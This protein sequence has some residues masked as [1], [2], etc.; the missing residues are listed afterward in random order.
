M[1]YL[2]PEQSVTPAL[3]FLIVSVNNINC[4]M[5]FCVFI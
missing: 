1:S 4:H 2:L 5:I 3:L